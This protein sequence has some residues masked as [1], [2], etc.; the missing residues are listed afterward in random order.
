MPDTAPT[1]PVPSRAPRPTG[2]PD[3]TELTQASYTAEADT[4]DGLG[5][6]HTALE[7]P[8]MNVS[9]PAQTPEDVAACSYTPVLS[10][11]AGPVAT[12]VSH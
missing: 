5:V 1:R 4:R 3:N 10:S 9:G 11:V 7:V 12:P 8:L 2:E 6:Q